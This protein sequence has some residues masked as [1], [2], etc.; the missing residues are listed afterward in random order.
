MGRELTRI[1]RINTNFISK[2]IS[3][4]NMSIL[5]SFKKKKIR[6]EVKEDKKEVKEVKEG[7]KE[8]VVEKVKKVTKEMKKVEEVKSVKKRGKNILGKKKKVDKEDIPAEYYSVLRSP[9]LTER[10][11][12]LM[13]ENKYVFK[14]DFG[15]NKIQVRKAIENLYGVSVAKVNVINIPRKRIRYGQGFGFK[16]GYRKAIVSLKEGERIELVESQ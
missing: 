2:N 5:D 1:K 12:D 16:T 11:N 15:A 14:I 6:K 9:H 4:K 10:A 7:K 8:T 3:L 13:K